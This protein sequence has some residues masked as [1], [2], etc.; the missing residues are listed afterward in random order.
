MTAR[1]ALTNLQSVAIHESGHAVVSHALGLNVQLVAMWNCPRGAFEGI[2]NYLHGEGSTL[3]NVA[4]ACA[5]RAAISLVDSTCDFELF[6][7]GSPWHPSDMGGDTAQSNPADLPPSDSPSPSFA[8]VGLM[9]LSVD[10]PAPLEVGLCDLQQ[11]H[12]LLAG[13]D[14][15]LS[16]KHRRR[17]LR[18]QWDRAREICRQRW[19]GVAD[20]ADALLAA[21][22]VA[23]QTAS[24]TGGPI[25]AEISGEKLTRLLGFA[26]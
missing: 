13:L 9:L 11:A 8:P 19:A 22:G 5:G 10:D 21:Y 23:E 12:A 20:I 17:I 15:A 26:K 4:I 24:I 18:F 3:D 16:D 6:A 1:V 2:V 7:F 14:P 25:R